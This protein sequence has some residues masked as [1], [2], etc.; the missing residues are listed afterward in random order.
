[1]P[2]QDSLLQGAELRILC[3]GGSGERLV[4]CKGLLQLRFGCRHARCGNLAAEIL[5]VGH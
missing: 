2:A 4:G 3:S 1:M 5:L